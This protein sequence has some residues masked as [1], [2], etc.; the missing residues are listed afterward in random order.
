MILI[1]FWKLNAEEIQFGT[2]EYHS[3]SIKGKQLKISP[4]HV[5]DG[6]NEWS[7]LTHQRSCY[8]TMIGIH[9]TMNQNYFN[10]W[11]W[12]FVV[13]TTKSSRTVTFHPYPFPTDHDSTFCSYQL[14]ALMFQLILG[15]GCNISEFRSRI[16]HDIEVIKCMKSS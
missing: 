16:I 1:F 11:R 14:P 6:Y 5:Y 15:R 9:H 8:V 2:L 13:I 10:A 3:A 4:N 12:W 7:L